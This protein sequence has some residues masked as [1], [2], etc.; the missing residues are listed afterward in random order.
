MSSF[1]SACLCLC[2]SALCSPQPSVKSMCTVSALHRLNWG[3]VS[4]SSAARIQKG[5]CVCAYVIY[6]KFGHW[7][8]LLL[9]SSTVWARVLDPRA[10]MNVELDLTDTIGSEYTKHE[11]TKAFKA[12][13]A[14]HPHTGVNAAGGGGRASVLHSVSVNYFCLSWPHSPLCSQHVGVRGVMWFLLLSFHLIFT[15]GDFLHL[16]AHTHRSDVT[17]FW[18]LA[19]FELETPCL[20]KGR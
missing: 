6:W 13:S 3:F 18:R 11:A 15:G 10:D 9:M 19:F 5:R 7:S 8:E 16:T 20:D 2:R 1:H 14:A 17:T 4:I 12:H